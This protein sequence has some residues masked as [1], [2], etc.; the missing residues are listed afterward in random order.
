MT[1]IRPVQR[2]SLVGLALVL[3]VP[4]GI[5]TAQ[6]KPVPAAPQRPPLTDALERMNESIDALTRKVWPS[7]VQILVTSYGPREQTTPG[8]AGLVV[9]QGR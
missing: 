9:G 7:V 4:P 1:G 8:E 5:A 3:A 6:Q 2:L